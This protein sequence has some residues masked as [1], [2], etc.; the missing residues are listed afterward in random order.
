[1]A[2]RQNHSGLVELNMIKPTKVG[3]LPDYR[4]YLEFSDGTKGEVDLSARVGVGVFRAWKD[5]EF[6]SKVSIGEHRE[7]RWNNE[8]ELCADSLYLSITGKSPQE[9]FPSL[10]ERSHA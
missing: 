1:M 10:R 4:I 3:A 9:L 7:I 8:I 6:F 5:P 2:E